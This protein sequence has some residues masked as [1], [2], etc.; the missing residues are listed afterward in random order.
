[1]GQPPPMADRPP[2]VQAGD[3][4]TI[5][6]APMLAT[7]YRA[8]LLGIR[9]R[10]ADGLPPGDLLQLAR[11]LRRA[12]MSHE[13]H[14]VAPD[15]SDPPRWNGQDPSDL[16]SVADAAGLLRL[17]K[18]QVQRLAASPGGLDG[19]RVGRTWMLV[20]APVLALAEERA[21]DRGSYGVPR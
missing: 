15:S 2:I 19:V 13:R 5:R 17:S 10:R 3:C 1:M 8:V 6:T 20:R 12:H 4:V 11:A 9:Q 18:R 7:T 21:R 14:E 16:I